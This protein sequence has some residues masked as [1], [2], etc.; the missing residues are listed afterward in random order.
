MTF[1][2]SLGLAYNA[3]VLQQDLGFHTQQCNGFAVLISLQTLL[4]Y[5]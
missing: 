4:P 2:L 1:T 3:N 5:T